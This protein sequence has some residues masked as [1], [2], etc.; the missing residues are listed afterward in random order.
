MSNDDDL[1]TSKI[2]VVFYTSAVMDPDGTLAIFCRET[3]SRWNVQQNVMCYQNIYFLN[4]CKPCYAS[5]LGRSHILQCVS[6]VTR[7]CLPGTMNVLFENQNFDFDLSACANNPMA[8]G[9]VDMTLLHHRKGLTSEE[10]IKTSA[11][12]PTISH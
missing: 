6:D 4:V 3:R 7:Y 10:S 9:S 8:D 12:T 1:S 5:Q 11:V 2:A